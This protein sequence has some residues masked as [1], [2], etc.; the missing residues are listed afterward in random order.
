M[1]HLLQTGQLPGQQHL[2]E[3]SQA[4]VEEGAAAAQQQLKILS[5]ESCSALMPELEALRGLDQVRVL[6]EL[7]HHV[8]RVL[9]SG[10][11]T[12]GAAVLPACLPACLSCLPARLATRLPACPHGLGYWAAQINQVCCFVCPQMTAPCST[13]CQHGWRGL[14]TGTPPRCIAACFGTAC[15]CAPGCPA[16]E[17]RCC[18]TSTCSSRSLAACMGRMLSW[19]GCGRTEA[20]R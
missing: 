19:R 14:C 13:R 11:L 9:K 15:T 10:R 12:A 1:E 17:T 3:G 8:Q 16:H 20:G 7:Q 18:R 4:A 6:Q 5:L 2:G